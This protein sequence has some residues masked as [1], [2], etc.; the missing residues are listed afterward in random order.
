[1]QPDLSGQTAAGAGILVSVLLRLFFAFLYLRLE[2]SVRSQDEAVD[3]LS[4][5]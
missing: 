5:I 1:M 4:D 3:C 2:K